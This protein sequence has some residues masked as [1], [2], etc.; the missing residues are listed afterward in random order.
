[1][2]LP[3]P[4][5][6]GWRGDSDVCGQSGLVLGHPQFQGSRI[7]TEA[8]PVGVHAE[9]R[10]G[11]ETWHVPIQASGARAP[12]SEGGSLSTPASAE[13]AAVARSPTYV[14]F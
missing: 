5:P 6:E 9:V 3:L 12:Q 2:G 11:G 1:M 4:T 8:G 10:W 7:V 14:L 13:K